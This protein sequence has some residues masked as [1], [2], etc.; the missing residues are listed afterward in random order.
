MDLLLP[1]AGKSSRFPGVKPKWMLTHPSGNIMLIEAIRGLPL[2]QFNNIYV[3]GREDFIDQNVQDG[4]IECFRKINCHDKV[5]I[6]IVPETQSQPETVAACIEKKGL[7]GAIF[8][9][10]SDNYYKQEELVPNSVSFE[11]LDE[12][13]N[14][15][16]KSKSYVVLDE[17]HV[18]TN[19]VEK[20]VISSN[21]CVGGY[22]FKSAEKFL[23]TFNEIKSPDAYVSHVIYKMILDGESF[24]G[25]KTQDFLDWGT[26]NDWDEFKSSYKTLFLDIDGVIFKN[27]GQFFK[28]NWHKVEPIEEN[29]EYLKNLDLNKYHVV[30]TTSRPLEFKEI[31]LKQLE[32]Q[33]V[34]FHDIVFGLPHAK[35]IVVNDYAKTNPYPSALAVNI[36]RNNPKL[37]DYIDG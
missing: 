25:V 33:G 24:R 20:H 10:D 21:F 6:V 27:S 22:C 32:E 9:K 30:L 37:K 31:T 29:V 15:C 23:S 36:E 2:G 19:I 8:I 13:G 35:R 4:L 11:S 1:I 17:N 34:R 7:T 3:I 5:E 14:I 28:P 12:I 18:L 16:P 26:L